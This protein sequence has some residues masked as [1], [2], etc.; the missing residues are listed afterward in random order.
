MNF[1]NGRTGLA[2]GMKKATDWLGRKVKTRVDMRNG[3]SDI[4]TG[5]V[6]TVTYVRSGLTLQSDACKCCGV[7]LYIR[8]V[9]A[10]DV[11]LLPDD[12][13]GGPDVQA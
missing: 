3:Y 13:K 9:E 10:R 5:T 8:G 4:P 1:R 2:P 11:Q 12:T 6:L 7:S